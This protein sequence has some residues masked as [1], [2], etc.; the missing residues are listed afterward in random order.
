MIQATAETALYGRHM[1]HLHKA[2]PNLIDRA[3]AVIVERVL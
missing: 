2:Y 3:I 1:R